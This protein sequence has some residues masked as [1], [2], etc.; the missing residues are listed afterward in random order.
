MIKEYRF[1][2]I[3]KYL[4]KD[5]DIGEDI[6]TAFESLSD[7]AIIFSPIIFGAQFLPILELLDIKDKLFDLG[8]KVYDYI[9]QKTELNY[10]ERTEQLKAAYA[11]ICYTAY[12]DVLQDGLPAKV[13]KKLKLKLEEK[14]S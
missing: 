9:A 5:S 12:F 4:R 2:D 8:R 1:K 14:R 6:L 3:E 10:I 13:R 7:A 11:L